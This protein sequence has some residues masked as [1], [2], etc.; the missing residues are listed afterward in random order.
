MMESQEAISE[1]PAQNTASAGS[2]AR[3]APLQP[4]P[5]SPTAATETTELKVPAQADNNGIIVNI[6]LIKPS[7]YIHASAF[8]EVSD[9]LIH[10]FYELGFIVKTSENSLIDDGVNIIL[11]AH[12]LS[13]ED[14]AIIPECSI[15]YNFEQITDDPAC[16]TP[17]LL[18]LYNR[19]DIWDYS[20]KNITALRKKGITSRITHVPVGY[21]EI[22]T[23]IAKAPVQDIDVLFYGSINERRRIVLDQLE[24]AGLKVERLFG[25]Y[26][27]ERD[28]YIARSKI[29]LNM[30]Y[31]ESK[32]FEHV[33]VSYLLANRKAVVSEISD[34]ADINTDLQNAVAMVS[35]TTYTTAAPQTICVLRSCSPDPTSPPTL[36]HQRKRPQ[37]LANHCPLY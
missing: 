20:Q 23:K 11:G 19:H 21:A 18:A 37:R 10:A 26:G 12:L 15:I 22:L 36:H 25:V 2:S 30:H 17:A 6:G 5:Q 35:L 34:L 13:E 24:Q 14:M 8:E 3:P 28:K 16:L 29:V 1:Y 32:I 4:A 27:E 31:Y 33:R 7:G 9:S